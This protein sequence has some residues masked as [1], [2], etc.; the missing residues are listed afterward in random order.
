MLFKKDFANS[1]IFNTHIWYN[2][3]QNK[4]SRDL[5][6]QIFAK[7]SNSYW[8]RYLCAFNF[9]KGIKN[10]FAAG[11]QERFNS[12]LA[13]VYNLHVTPSKCIHLS[14]L[15]PVHASAACRC[16]FG[17]QFRLPS[18]KT[19]FNLLQWASKIFHG[20]FDPSPGRGDGSENWEL[21]KSPNSLIFSIGAGPMGPAVAYRRKVN[22]FIFFLNEIEFSAS[23]FSWNILDSRL[24]QQ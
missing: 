3:K 16:Y 4:D 11:H 18:E 8:K 12:A 20:W 6:N 19:I 22:S 9:R 2:Y 7:Y 13:R 1:R 14:G 5:F 15:T 24:K 10:I 21:K 23:I 17:V